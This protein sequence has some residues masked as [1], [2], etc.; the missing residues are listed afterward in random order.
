MNN[1]RRIK[2]DF[3]QKC[4]ITFLH[5]LKSSQGNILIKNLSG[6]ASTKAYSQSKLHTISRIRERHKVPTSASQIK[7]CWGKEKEIF[8][9]ENDY[10][11]K[12]QEVDKG[13]LVETALSAPS[14]ALTIKHNKRRTVRNL[15]LLML[16]AMVNN[17][18]FNK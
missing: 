14:A 10:Q 6:P 17:K 4:K 16:K 13:P 11:G 9:L 8:A 7:Y 3:G 12:V 2:P 5:L 18:K 1:R 15:E